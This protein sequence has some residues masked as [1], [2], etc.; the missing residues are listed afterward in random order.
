MIR[1]IKAIY[2]WL[3]SP[4]GTAFEVEPS[5]KQIAKAAADAERAK[6]IRKM[7]GKPLPKME[8]EKELGLR[9]QMPRINRRR[10]YSR[11]NKK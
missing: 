10:F 1:Y 3:N 9:L 11:G 8:V 5:K 7:D 2:K 4:N 6:R